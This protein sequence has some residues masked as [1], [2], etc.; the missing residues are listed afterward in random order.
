MKKLLVATALGA[1]LTFATPMAAHAAP[2]DA[3]P[4]PQDAATNA[5][6]IEKANTVTITRDAKSRSAVGQYA[7]YGSYPTRKGVILVTPDWF[8]GLIPTGHAAI[9]YSSGTVVE[10]VSRGVTTGS[11]NWYATKTQAYGVT[12]RNTTHAQDATAA[13]WAY[14]KIG[15][16]YNYNYFDTGTRSRFYCSQL[17]W[18]AYKDNFGINMNTDTF[19]NA[20][21]P[22]ELV[23]TSQNQLIWRK[24]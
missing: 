8:K 9:I 12:A 1:A 21:H 11:N 15:K 19:G 2:V 23:N 13:N 14:G 17:V 20:I 5:T 10:S 6:L 24:A 16:P 4:S 22:M 18:A 7:P 3:G